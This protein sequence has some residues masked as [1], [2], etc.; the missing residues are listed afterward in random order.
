MKDPG[1][2]Q[3]YYRMA[4]VALAIFFAANAANAA[5]FTN[6]KLPKSN[7]RAEMQSDSIPSVAAA[8][9][10]EENQGEADASIVGLWH[11]TYLLNG[12]V[13]F[14]SFD[15]WHSDGTEFENAYSNPIEG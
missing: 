7:I 2:K 11:V 14:V 6:S 1:R 9:Q 12:Q 4:L 10:V 5:C 8:A 3:S 15:Q 13:F